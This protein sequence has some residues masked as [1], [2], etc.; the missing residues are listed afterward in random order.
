MIERQILKVLPCILHTL[1]TRRELSALPNF[2]AQSIIGSHLA[3]TCQRQLQ[4]DELVCSQQLESKIRHLTTTKDTG[5]MKLDA[6]R[7]R[8]MRQSAGSLHQDHVL[9]ESCGMGLGR[10]VSCVAFP[11]AFA[12]VHGPRVWYE[13]LAMISQTNLS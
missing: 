3:D 12:S 5:G 11:Q 8:R 10:L 9:S 2:R 6:S 13:Y 1:E 4:E 7:D